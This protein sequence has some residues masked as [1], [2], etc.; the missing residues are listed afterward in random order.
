MA[1]MPD[2]QR[3]I[4]TSA[5]AAVLGLLSLHEWSTYELAQQVRRSLRWFWPRAERAVYDVPKKLVAAGFATATKEWTGRRPRTVYAITDKGRE[6]LRLWLGE[7]SAPPSLE[8]EAEMRIFFADSGST[9][10]LLA[11]I[12]SVESHA[13][14]RLRAIEVL[15]AEQACGVTPY[16]RRLAL[17]VLGLRGQ[18]NRLLETLRWARWARE[19][20]ADWPAPDR[21]E[22]WSPQEVLDGML[23]EIR[24]EVGPAEETLDAG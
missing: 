10:D 7:E 4:P 6:G 11:A 9:E 14:A 3:T 19:Q 17:N 8:S 18:V 24:S 16:P 5:E 23:E 12:E 20:V 1:A 2:R 13:V 22:G 21:A 15:A